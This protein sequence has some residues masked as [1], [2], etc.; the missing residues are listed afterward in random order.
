M[1]I[2]MVGIGLIS[3]PEFRQT[4]RL[5]GFHVQGL[6]GF[7][8]RGLVSSMPSWSRAECGSLV[9]GSRPKCFS[10]TGFLKRFGSGF[11]ARTCFCYWL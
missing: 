2:F 4:Q 3:I 11:R 5:T 9:L 7:P 8:A 6:I 1:K 10:F